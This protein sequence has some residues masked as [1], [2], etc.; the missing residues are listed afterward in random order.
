MTYPGAHPPGQPVDLLGLAW[1]EYDP[2]TNRHRWSPQMFRLSGLDP[3]AGEPDLAGWLSL[4]HPQDRAAVQQV[5]AVA[6]SGGT[7]RLAEFRIVR[8]DGQVRSVQAWHWAR[9]DAHGTVIGLF[10]TTLDLTEYGAAE[11]TVRETERRLVAAQRL[12]G[13]ALWELDV[14]TGRLTWSDEMFALLGL[15]PGEVKPDLDFWLQQVHPQDREECTRLSETALAAMEGYENVFRVRRADGQTRWLRAWSSVETGDDGRPARVWGATIDITEREQADAERRADQGRL[16]DAYALTGLAW[17]EWHV[18]AGTI[19]W[20]EGMRALAGRGPDEEVSIQEWLAMVDPEDLAASG[21]LERAAM[22]HG[23]PYL[24]VFRIYLP[25]GRTR[26]LQS[27]TGPLRRPDGTVYGLR[28]ATLDV[29]ERTLA[30]QAQAASEE[31]F[32]VAFDN[33]PTA[34]AMVSLTSDPPGQVLRANGAFARLLGYQPDQVLSL[35]L[36]DWTF[37]ADLAGSRDRLQALAAGEGVAQSYDNR[38]R[39]RDGSGV[40]TGVTSTVANDA[41]GRPLYAITHFVDETERRRHEGELERLAMTDELTGLANRSVVDGQL[42]RALNRLADGSGRLVGL[43]LLDVDRFKLVNDTLGHPIGD[44]LIAELAT[45]LRM[46]TAG[47][48]TAARLGGDEFLVLVEGARDVPDLEDI[49]VRVLTALRR[50]CTL[51]SGDT[52][53]ATSSLGIAFTRDPAATPSELLREADLAL[54]EAKDAGRD[55]YAV[56]GKQL[57]ARTVQRVETETRLR[58]ALRSGGLRVALQPVVDLRGETVVAAEALVRLVHLELG[59]LPPA[60]FIGVAED[61]GLIVQVDTWVAREVIAMIADDQAAVRRGHP[62]RLPPRIAVNV[63]GRTIGHPGFVD[64]IRAALAEHGVPASRLLVELTESTLLDTSTGVVDAALQELRALGIEVGVDD[65]GTGYSA[66]AYLQNLPLSFLK[67][68][69]SFVRQLGTT[70][71]ADAVV[72]A[73]IALAHAHGL[74]V[75]AEGVETRAQ[76]DALRQIGCDHGQGWLYGRPEKLSALPRD[77]SRVSSPH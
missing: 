24:H 38:L 35:R 62:G 21:P 47:W 75:I 56:Y 44:D 8:P 51:D 40:H 57:R 65:F 49:A 46:V 2:A 18:D 29:T 71:R 27:W 70:P 34:M 63:S 33:A 76:A 31:Q 25:D 9:T 48:A 12:T 50:P 36:D 67:V 7:A 43:L 45:R 14:P 42:A 17:W 77:W 58:E 10:G 23:V 5:S 37:P 4:V 11:V 60:D 6:L 13:L 39:R 32:R 69:M 52:V 72:A 74:Y 28:G 53:L 61:T 41:T 64:G 66:L 20:S 19:T 30:E 15:T 59:E 1:W 22:E 55:R 3:A 68:D 73:I 54:Y 16:A 26:H